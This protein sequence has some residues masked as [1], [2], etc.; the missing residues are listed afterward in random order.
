MFFK[1]LKSKGIVDGIATAFE[2]TL[3]ARLNE[4]EGSPPGQP[5]YTSAKLKN[6]NLT[7]FSKFTAGTDLCLRIRKELALVR[8]HPEDL[9]YITEAYEF[10]YDEMFDTLPGD[11]YYLYRRPGIAEP[12]SPTGEIR[13]NGDYVMY[14]VEQRRALGQR[15]PHHIT[16]QISFNFL[17][18]YSH[19]KKGTRF[20]MLSLASYQNH[21]DNRY[22]G[23]KGWVDNIED[24]YLASGQ[25]IS[26]DGLTVDQSRVHGGMSTLVVEAKRNMPFTLYKQIDAERYTIEAACC[27]HLRAV[28]GAEPSLA[29]G[30]LVRCRGLEQYGGQEDQIQSVRYGEIRRLQQLLGERTDADMNPEEAAARLEKATG[31][32]ARAFFHED[33]NNHPNGL[34]VNLPFARDIGTSPFNLPIMLPSSD[35]PAWAGDY[36]A[37]HLSDTTPY[38]IDFDLDD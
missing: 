4:T 31:F 34:L 8:I 23:A 27:L 14:R 6:V 29:R 9:Q 30:Y 7:D 5:V 36:P 21:G 12:T 3:L 17:R 19:K 18:F 11:E 20:M 2:G 1:A 33:E 16:S 15:P 10:Y 24:R 26:R 35:S 22:L 37:R 28:Y 25:I 32:A 13:L 38:G